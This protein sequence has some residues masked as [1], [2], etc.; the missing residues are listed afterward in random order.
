LFEGFSSTMRLSDFPYPYIP[1]VPPKGSQSGPHCSLSRSDMGSPGSRVKCFRTCYGVS[2]RA[3]SKRISRY[4][5]APYCLPLV[6]QR[7]HPEL[8]GLHGSIPGPHVPLS[9]LH[10]CSYEQ[11][12][13]TRGR[14]GSLFLHRVT[15]L[16]T[17]LH[18]F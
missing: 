1:D 11:R 7:Q 4:R 5:S 2:D 14:C 9:T 15:I 3:G 16:F 12:L 18:R 13:M 6:V 8:W 10:P 17:T